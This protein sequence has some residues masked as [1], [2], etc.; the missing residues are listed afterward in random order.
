M[1]RSTVLGTAGAVALVVS[2]H[3]GD[4]GGYKDYSP[5]A[6]WAG[7]YAGAE[8]GGGIGTSRKDWSDPSAT[9]GN[10]T[11]DG[12]IGGGTAGYNMQWGH[13]VAGLEAD[14]S[15]SA[16]SGSANCG[17]PAFTCATNTDWLATVRPRVGY[18]FGQF[19][20]Y[21]TG[22]LA[23]GDVHVHS[24]LKAPPGGKGDD[25]TDVETGWT[26]G[27]GVETLI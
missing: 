12:V 27:A 21:V 13:L 8:I 15:G 23:V 11:V 5:A 17:N 22:G 1:V 19:M 3:A 16:V 18:A 14:F 26:A 4:I 7:F 9:T 25:Y 20:P 10:F 6:A 2:A 24:F